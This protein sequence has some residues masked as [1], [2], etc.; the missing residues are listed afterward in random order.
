MMVQESHPGEAGGQKA[1]S[2]LPHHFVRDIGTALEIAG[3]AANV[4]V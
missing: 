2:T 4:R 1:F 3:S